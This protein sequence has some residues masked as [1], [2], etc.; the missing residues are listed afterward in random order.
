MLYLK[1]LNPKKILILG[2]DT[3]KV[4]KRNVIDEVLEEEEENKEDNES[5]A[6][7]KADAIS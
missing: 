5:E 2:I 6:E 7:D 1:V 4:F 3:L